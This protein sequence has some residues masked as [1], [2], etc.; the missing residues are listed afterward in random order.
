MLFGKYIDGKYIWELAVPCQILKMAYLNLTQ[1]S[2]YKKKSKKKWN[3]EN[4]VEDFLN[5][6]SVFSLA[7]RGQKAVNPVI[8][9]CLFISNIQVFDGLLRRK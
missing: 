9:I 2:I 6:C 3:F 7:E 8:I 1:I 4:G 5:H